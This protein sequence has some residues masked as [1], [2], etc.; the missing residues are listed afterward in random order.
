MKVNRFYVIE[1][2]PDAKPMTFLS[3]LNWEDQEDVEREQRSSP[4]S[5]AEMMGY[6]KRGMFGEQEGEIFFFFFVRIRIVLTSILRFSCTACLVERRSLKSFEEDSPTSESGWQDPNGRFAFPEFSDLKSPYPPPHNPGESFFPVAT[7]PTQYGNQSFGGRRSSLD[8]SADL[9]AL[10]DLQSTIPPSQRIMN[11]SSM[12]VN[13]LSDPMAL[14]MSTNFPLMNPDMFFSLPIIQQ[15]LFAPP[16][17]SMA[18]EASVLSHPSGMIGH[19][20]GTMQGP[21]DFAQFGSGMILPS[22]GE[23]GPSGAPPPSAVGS[24]A[25]GPM[26]GS[27]APPYPMS[28]GSSNSM[29][30]SSIPMRAGGIPLGPTLPAFNM[31]PQPPFAVPQIPFSGDSNERKFGRNLI[32]ERLKYHLVASSL[33]NLHCVLPMFHVPTL[34]VQVAEDT[35]RFG[36]PY[37]LSFS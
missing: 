14:N 4:E 2:K 28:S 24:S 31:A 9:S 37:A 32:P 15:N 3:F 30:P 11:S 22:L 19:N 23:P 1:N 35:V 8:G 29:I 26:S 21:N 10:R 25:P 13:P 18:G 16:S 5:Y 27:S 33:V 17:A 7:A 20:G 6:N 36:D 12:L 34:L